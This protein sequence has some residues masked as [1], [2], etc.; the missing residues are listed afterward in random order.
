MSS[1]ESEVEQGGEEEL[2]QQKMELQLTLETLN[3][4]KTDHFLELLKLVFEFPRIKEGLENE[5]I[6][7]IQKK[8]SLMAAKKGEN[9]S[10]LMVKDQKAMLNFSWMSV[11]QEME[12]VCPFLLK[13]MSKMM[14]G[15]KK[16]KPEELEHEKALIIPKLGSI[17]GIL[18]QTRHHE[19]SLIQRVTHCSLLDVPVEQKVYDLLQPMGYVLCHQTG[20]NIIHDLATKN[21]QFLIECLKRGMQLHWLGDNMNVSTTVANMRMKHQGKHK[22]TYD[23]YSTAAIFTDYKFPATLSTTAPQKDFKQLDL[24]DFRFTEA[25]WVTSKYNYVVHLARTAHKYSSTFKFLEKV[26]PKHLKGEYSD[27]IAKKTNAIPMETLDYNEQYLQDSVKILDFFEAKTQEIFKEAGLELA[28]DARFQKM[29]DQ[30]TRERLSQA[31]A[32]LARE[33]TATGRCEHLG[34]FVFL[35]FHLCMNFGIMELDMLYKPDSSGD[36]GTMKAEVDRIMRKNFDSDMRKAYQQN[37]EFL[38]IWEDAYIMEL[39]CHYFGMETKD[40]PPTKH[41]PPTFDT[42][43]DMKQWMEDTF[44]DILEEFVWPKIK[45]SSYETVEVEGT[46]FPVKFPDGRILNLKIHPAPEPAQ[47]YVRNHALLVVEF[48]LIRKELIDSCKLPDR[49]RTIRLIKILMWMFKANKPL[50][51]KYGIECLRFLVQQLYV[52]SEQRATQSFYGMFINTKG[53]ID[54]FVASDMWMEWVVRVVKKHITPMMANQ[55]AKY[56]Q[57]KTTSLCALNQITLGF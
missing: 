22:K 23:M 30:L 41:I 1:S 16:R 51:S 29:G 55:N 9:V 17:Y 15:I 37:T 26:L 42:T 34:P 14:L 36:I 24:D 7:E 50:V 31:M 2:E 44:G 28:D 49:Q 20:T 38:D 21:Q 10:Y 12:R 54:S 47:D 46:F 40:S 35:F 4:A 18:M 3:A 27:L 11:L 56:I 43:D 32:L 45:T 57:E 39:I 25:D 13:L 5:I 33:V 52:L 8:V 6:E 19:L 53:K 48:G